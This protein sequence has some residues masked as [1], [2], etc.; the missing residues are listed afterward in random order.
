MGAMLSPQCK[1]A[2]YVRLSVEDNGADAKDSIQN[3]IEYLKEYINRN[4][5]D[6][7]LVKVYE[8]NGTTGTN[9]L[10][11]GWQNL[12]EDVKSG[13]INCILVKDF[14]RMGRNYIEVGN[15]L[16]KIFPF[17]GPDRKNFRV[18]GSPGLRNPPAAP[19]RRRWRPGPGR[20]R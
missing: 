2:I 9:F 8:D 10:R 1:T 18:P 20:C 5:E 4:G 17:M 15:Y 6:L 11:E 13:K 12:I 7:R 14:S 16:E 19:G 3:Q